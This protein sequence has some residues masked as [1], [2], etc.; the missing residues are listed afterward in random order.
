MT[1]GGPLQRT[2]TIIYRIY[3][4]GIQRSQM[5]SAAAMSIVVAGLLLLLT[6]INFQVSLRE[7]S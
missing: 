7:Q 2:E 1:A 5:G 3:I 6:S 4:E